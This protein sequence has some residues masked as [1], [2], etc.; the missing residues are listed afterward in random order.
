MVRRYPTSAAPPATERE[1]A[2]REQE[3][4][5]GRI[6]RAARRAAR[7][8]T[9]SRRAVW[10][11]GGR[12]DRLLRRLFNNVLGLAIARRRRSFARRAGLLGGRPILGCP[13]RRRALRRAR[14][15][16]SV[17]ATLRLAGLATC[18]LAGRPGSDSANA[19]RGP[20]HR[21]ERATQ[22]HAVGGSEVPLVRQLAV[23]L[24]HLPLQALE[25]GPDRASS[26]VAHIRRVTS[27]STVPG[28][29][30][31]RNE[32]RARDEGRGSRNRRPRTETRPCD[33]G[34]H[35]SPHAT[36]SSP[37]GARAGAP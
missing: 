17:D 3:C 13:L 27:R 7:A 12:H 5:S 20:L 31:H 18:V 22:R 11:R 15:A 30:R 37:C 10:R 25:R 34:G 8:S 6:A 9:T 19:S 24:P 4:R 21:S 16:G 28:N 29:Q 1:E 23:K 14:R 36:R 35:H 33:G 2:Y 32:E 26:V